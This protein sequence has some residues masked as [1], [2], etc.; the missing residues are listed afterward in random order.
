MKMVI[1]ESLGS[2]YVTS[3]KNYEARIQNSRAIHKMDGFN[4][5]EEII[6]YFINLY[7]DTKD[8]YIIVC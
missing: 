8:D 5:P 1:F 4:S 7:H 6:E 3:Q 2:Y